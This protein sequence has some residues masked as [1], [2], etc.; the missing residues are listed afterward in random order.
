MRKETVGDWLISLLMQ[1]MAAGSDLAMSSSL[2]F[3]L[4]TF[5]S[6]NLL[7]LSTPNPIAPGR[8]TTDEVE[9]TEDVEWVN[10]R[11]ELTLKV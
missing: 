6:S 8:V 4:S 3:F 5:P 10:Q 7:W 11:L 2:G 9:K 1:V